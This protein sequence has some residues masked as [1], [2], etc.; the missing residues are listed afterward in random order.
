MIHWA[1]QISLADMERSSFSRVRQRVGLPFQR[2]G[3][4]FLEEAVTVS[5]MTCSL[6]Q[7]VKNCL[8]WLI[9]ESLRQVV[10]DAALQVIDCTNL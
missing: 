4:P 7:V 9:A 1:M 10:K 2:V 6:R 8:F 5:G 3:L